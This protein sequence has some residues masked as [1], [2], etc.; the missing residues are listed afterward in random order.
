MTFVDENPS[1]STQTDDTHDFRLPGI[2]LDEA[3]GVFTATTAQG[4]V[5]AVARYK[6]VLFIKTI[7]TTP[8]AAVR[9]LHPRGNITVILEAIRPDDPA[10]RPAAR[11]FGSRW[12]AQGGYQ[13][14]CELDWGVKRSALTIALALAWLC[15]APAARADGPHFWRIASPDHEQTFAYGSEQRR[16]WAERGPGIRHLAVLLDFTNDP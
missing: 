10:M 2:T 1:S 3:K 16:V 4:E 13:P 7:V 8:N 15:L 11:Q 5:I 12:H 6:N 14:G 9:V